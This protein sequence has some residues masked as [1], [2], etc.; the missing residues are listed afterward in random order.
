MEEGNGGQLCSKGGW[1]V[2]VETSRVAV[3]REVC[4]HRELIVRQLPSPSPQSAYLSYRGVEWR[5][6]LCC[7]LVVLLINI[8][9]FLTSPPRVMMECAWINFYSASWRCAC[10]ATSRRQNEQHLPLLPVLDSLR[11]VNVWIEAIAICRCAFSMVGKGI[12]CLL[13]AFLSKGLMQ[14]SSQS[15]HHKKGLFLFETGL[16]DTVSH[17]QGD[18]LFLLKSSSCGYITHHLFPLQSVRA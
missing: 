9:P 4:T 18:F 13:I 1:G 15:C 2:G 16:S 6:T 12:A 5:T 10:K 11:Y 7:S 17:A 8:C 3:K 14:L